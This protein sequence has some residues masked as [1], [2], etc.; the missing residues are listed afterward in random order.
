MAQ[1]KQRI[2]AIGREFGSGGHLVAEELSKRLEL[3]MYDKNI[4]EH[5]A[6]LKNVDVKNW[7]KYD[8]HPK[9]SPIFR[10]VQGYSNSPGEVIAQ[11]QF[12]YLRRRAE[13]GESFVVLGRCGET[14]LKDYDG[15]VSIFLLADEDSKIKRIAERENLSMEAARARM[16]SANLKRKVYHNNHSDMKWGDSRNYDLCINSSRLGIDGTVDLIMEYLDKLWNTE[17]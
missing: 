7:E 17:A 16:K 1:E 15:L 10:N 4:L 8:E 5:I 3:P 11:M 6:E 14:V 9:F 2:I 13:K 12:E